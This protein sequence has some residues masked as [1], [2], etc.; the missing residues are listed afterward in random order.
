MNKDS[1]V[2]KGVL[3]ILKGILIILFTVLL[4]YIG[5]QASEW[6]SLKGFSPY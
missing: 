2:L 4:A 1:K 3:I 6:S 5:I